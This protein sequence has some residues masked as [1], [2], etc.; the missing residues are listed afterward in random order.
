[1]FGCC[2]F[3]GVKFL[4]G[5]EGSTLISKIASSFFHP[6][7]TDR[8]YFMSVS[9]KPFFIYPSCPAFV[10][11]NDCGQLLIPQNGSMFGNMTTFPN[12]VT[13]ACD[14]GF[15]IKGSKVRQCQANRTW[16]GSDTFCDGK[17]RIRDGIS[18]KTENFRSKC[19]GF[20]PR[21]HFLETISTI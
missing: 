19:D 16:T 13:F 8:I 7:F 4:A 3:F 5:G 2:T 1:M 10:S 17:E 6:Q 18:I 21:K 12:K 11:A 9:K 15:I 14:D 20:S